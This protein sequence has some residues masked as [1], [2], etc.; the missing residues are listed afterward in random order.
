VRRGAGQLI[1][2]T[3]Y[4]VAAI[5]LALSTDALPTLWTVLAMKTT[6]PGYFSKACVKNNTSRVDSR[7]TSAHLTAR[8]SRR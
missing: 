4:R 1:R 7:L 5:G 3:R 8:C 6:H 2:R